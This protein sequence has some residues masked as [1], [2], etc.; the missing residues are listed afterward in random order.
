[1]DGTV[2]PICRKNQDKRTVYNGHKKVHGIKFQSVVT[3]NGLIA[4]L[5][6]QVEGSKHDSGILAMSGLLNLLE[7]HSF[8]PDDQPLC[9]YGGPAYPHSVFLQCPFERRPDLTVQEQAFNQSMSRVRISVEWLFG[10]IVNY[11]TGPQ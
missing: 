4:N 3:P 6:G 10:D 1:M 9:I 11:F 7:Q 2:R 5:F 8:T